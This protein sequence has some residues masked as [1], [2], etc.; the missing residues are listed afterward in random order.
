MKNVLS[1]IT[2]VMLLMF[3][4]TIFSQNIPTDTLSIMDKVEH[5][6]VST[7]DEFITKYEPGISSKLGNLWEFTKSTSKTMYIA[8]IKYLIVKDS[9][10]IVIGLIIIGLIKMLCN[11]LNRLLNNNAFL[12]EEVSPEDS[13]TD[14]EKEMIRRDNKKFK[15]Y[16]GIMT[17]FAPNLFYVGLTIVIYNLLPYLYNLSILIIS[18]EVRVVMELTNIYKSL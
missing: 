18:P 12:F 11:R 5:S 6:T 16:N 1:K 15:F 8:F 17:T 13:Y 2:L 3:S 9:Y 4:I 10:P 14:Y 7:M